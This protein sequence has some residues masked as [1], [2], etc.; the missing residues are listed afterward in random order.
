MSHKELLFIHAGGYGHVKETDH[1][2]FIGLAAPHHRLVGIGIVRVVVG[3][4]ILGH[5]LQS[6]SGL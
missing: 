5:R 2:F 6:R 1:H 4:V 3:I